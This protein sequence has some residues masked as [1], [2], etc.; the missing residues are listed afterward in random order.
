MNGLLRYKLLFQAEILAV[1]FC[2][3]P[4][5]VYTNPSTGIFNIVILSLLVI[6]I[7]ATLIQVFGGRCTGFSENKFILAFS[8]KRNW[9]I[10]TRIKSEKE[11][12][13]R[14]KDLLCLEGIRFLGTLGVIFTHTSITYVYS[15]IDNPEYIEH[16]FD[17]LSA[18]VAFNTPLWMQVFFSISG[19][20]TTYFCLI[21]SETNKLSILKCILA[22][23]HRYIRLTPVAL[24]ALWFTMTW[25][26]RLG[27]GPQWAWLIQREAVDCTERWWYHAIY[28]HN[29]LPL[30]KYC[31]GHTWYLAVDMQL[32]VLG[33]VLL[34]IF[35][36]WRSSVKPIIFVLLI[37]STI[38]TGLVVHFFNLTPIITSQAPQIVNNMFKDSRNL[39][40][41]YLPLWMNLSGYLLGIATAFIFYHHQ[42]NGYKLSEAKWFRLAFHS[43]LPLAGAVSLAGVAFLAE[44]APPRWAAATYSALDRGLI[45]LGFCVFLLGCI[46]RCHSILRDALLWRG[47]QVIG[48]LTYSVF[49]VHFIIMRIIVAC[50]TQIGHVSA[51]SM[52]CLLVVGIVLSYIVAIPIYLFIEMPSIQLWKALTR[53][54]NKK[55]NTNQQQSSTKLDIVTSRHNTEQVVA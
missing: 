28:V 3:T 49:I 22:I 43:S 44:R 41:L 33:L 42:I 23:L 29:Y 47:F 26:P 10:L 20:L 16:M 9:Q 53:S 54:D 34:F 52:I 45:A 6:T 19:F 1:Q 12:D 2:N 48:R 36:R 50:N 4:E 5:T 13:H 38:A 24:F 37:G 46:S 31:M 25:Y 30:G 14:T 7:L 27:A 17:Q 35:L 11:F 51:Y 32:H 55:E 18:K 39:T 21:Y 8:L 40:I 15:Y